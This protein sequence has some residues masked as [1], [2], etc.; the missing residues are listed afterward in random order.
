MRRLAA[1]LLLIAG[2]P[3][4]LA[5]TGDWDFRVLLDGREIGRH[6]FTLAGAGEG[7]VLKSEAQ[8]DVRVL[9]ISAYRYVHEAV[10]RWQ[11]GCLESLASRTETNGE[12]ITV[13][14]QSQDGRLAVIGPAGRDLHDGCV[15]TFA[16]WDPRILEAERL[17]N[18]QT[19]ELVPVEV[20]PQGLETVS[21]RGQP[22]PASRHRISGPGL[23]IDLWYAD[24]RWVALE[25]LAEG[26]RR[27]RYELQ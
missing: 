26:G 24:G 7:V 4:S 13:S 22:R 16:Y 11:D 21:V 27:L 18:S 5:A 25:A 15:M 6:R 1:L 17:L 8:F 23:A 12:R 10:E 14:A 2:T 19:G 3:P 9:F 20:T